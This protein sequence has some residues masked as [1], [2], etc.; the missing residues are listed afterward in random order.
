MFDTKK[1]RFAIAGATA[2]AAIPQPW[3]PW[4]WP[5]PATPTTCSR[6]T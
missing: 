3:F 1:K 5:S 6:P 4:A 2:A